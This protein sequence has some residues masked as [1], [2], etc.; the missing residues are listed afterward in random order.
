[1]GGIRSHFLQ[2]WLL[3][4]AIE[5][6]SENNKCIVKQLSVINTFPDSAAAMKVYAQLHHKAPTR[7]FYVFHTDREQLDI[8]VLTSTKN[9]GM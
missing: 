1:M 7:E 2:Q 9:Q 4:E 5:A 6:Y 3:V 8:V